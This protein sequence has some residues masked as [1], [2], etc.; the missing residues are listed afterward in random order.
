M[1]DLAILTKK[2]IVT[3]AEEEGDIRNITLYPFGF[4]YFNEAISII[5]KYYGCYSKV[6]EKYNNEVQS[7]LGN[8]DYDAKT[9]KAKLNYLANS[10]DEVG[11]IVRNVMTQNGHLTH[12]GEPQVACPHDSSL[13]GDIARMIGFCCRQ[14]IDLNELHWGE[15]GILLAG[16]IEVNMD[17]FSQNED[18][19]TILK[20]TEKDQP[21]PQPKQKKDGEL[22]SVA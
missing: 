8:A 20:R 22:K 7:I 17:F 4:Q 14:E 3:F 10:F 11:Q 18:K 16:A 19:I 2:K 12:L 9:Q 21:K 13:G 5:N 6:Q 1:S 15:V